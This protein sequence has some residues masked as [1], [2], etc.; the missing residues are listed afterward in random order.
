MDELARLRVLASGLAPEALDA[1]LQYASCGVIVCGSDGRVTL[2]NVAAERIWAACITDPHPNLLRAAQQREASGPEEITAGTRRLVV[3]CAP[4]ATRGAIA[5][6]DD[7]TALREITHA[8]RTAHDRLSKLQ[9]VGAALAEARFPVDVARVVATQVGGVVGAHQ[10]VLAVPDAGELVIVESSGLS[11]R[12]ATELARFAVDADLPLARAYRS[13]IPVW[14][15]TAADRAREYPT[16]VP[17]E[18]PASVACLPLIVN[19]VKLGAIGFGFPTEHAF[20]A[21]ERALIDDLARNAALALE[22]TRLYESE[23]AARRRF[24]T[25]ARASRRFAEAASDHELLFDTIAGELAT[26]FA[27]S[28]LLAIGDPH[29][30]LLQRAHTREGAAVLVVGDRER[31]VGRSGKSFIDGGLLCVALRAR[32]RVIGTVTAVR[33]KPAFTQ[34]DLLLV[35]EL[36]QQAALVVDNV[37]RT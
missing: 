18:H 14:L 34:D 3:T 35:E 16:R 26:V 12:T 31:T 4:L 10:A 24:E 20:G 36:A 23:R 5:L 32:G 1:V 7:V 13:G 22:R 30:L 19:G 37:T 11:K 29:E 8:A 2:H 15:R 6:F 33:D 25:L 27:A 9:A 17:L 21:D 28:T